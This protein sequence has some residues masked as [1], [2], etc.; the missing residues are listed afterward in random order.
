MNWLRVVIVFTPV[1]N[2][3]STTSD[4]YLAKLLGPIER[5]LRYR[6]SATGDRNEYWWHT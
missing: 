3:D 5:I 6:E 4:V 1:D 2:I